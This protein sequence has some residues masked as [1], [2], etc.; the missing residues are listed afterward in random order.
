MSLTTWGCVEFILLLLKLDCRALLSWIKSAI[1][2]SVDL[3]L[4]LYVIQ[5]ISG[6]ALITNIN[7]TDVFH[8]H[9]WCLVYGLRDTRTVQI[10][11]YQGLDKVKSR[12][13]HRF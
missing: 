9:F 10:Q 3:I 4:Q 5:G 1:C 12:R 8:V 6:I 2:P 11:A 13:L 7:I